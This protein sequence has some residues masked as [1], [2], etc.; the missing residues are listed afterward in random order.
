MDAPVRRVF[1]EVV[2]LFGETGG[3]HAHTRTHGK[4]TRFGVHHVDTMEDAE[5]EKGRTVKM[6]KSRVSNEKKVQ[7]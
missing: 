3:Q 5:L 7:L 4:Q 1:T 2:R 6:R